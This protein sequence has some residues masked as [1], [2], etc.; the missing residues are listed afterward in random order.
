VSRWQTAAADY[1]VRLGWPVFCSGT[2]VWAYPDRFEALNVPGNV[3][4]LALAALGRIGAGAPVIEI[5]GGRPRWVFLTLPYVGE[6]ERIARLFVGQDVGYAH[7]LPGSPWVVHLPPTRHPD[8][9]ELSWVTSPEVRLP[10]LSLV[11]GAIQHAHT[12]RYSHRADPRSRRGDPP[13]DTSG[14]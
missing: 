6:V 14:P 9:A 12:G 10:R 1:R 4:H 8:R 11:A 5:P 7:G 2:V 3:G 13:T